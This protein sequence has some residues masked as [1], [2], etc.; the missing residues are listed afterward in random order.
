MSPL[1]VFLE[2]SIWHLW[3]DAMLGTIVKSGNCII[4]VAL[5]LNRVLLVRKQHEFV[6]WSMRSS[7]KQWAMA[8]V[9]V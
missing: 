9:K 4:G 6:S 3:R 1:F 2:L 8:K 7:S 5:L